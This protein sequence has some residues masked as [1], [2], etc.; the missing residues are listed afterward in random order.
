MQTSSFLRARRSLRLGGVSVL[1]LAAAAGLAGSSYGAGDPDKAVDHIRTASPIKHVI[2]IVGENRSFDHLFAT[3]VPKTPGERVLNLLSEHIINADGSPGPR[4]DRGHQFKIVAPPNGGKFFISADMV[5][6]QLYTT[7]PPPDIGGVPPV[8]IA[9]PIAEPPIFPPGDPGLPLEDQGL[10]ATGGTG[11]TG[12]PPPT[13]GPDTRITNVNNLQPGPF[14]MTGPTMPYDAYTGA[15]IHQYF[16]MYQQMDCAIDAEHVSPGNPTGCLHDLQSAVTT[17]FATLPTQTP[18]DTGQTMA[19]F[20]MQHGDVPFFKMLA[21]TYTMSDN[22][23]QPVMGGTGPDSQPLGFADQV[24]FSDGH[25]NAAAPPAANIYNPDPLTGTLNTY[26]HRAQW[27]DCSNPTGQ[28]GVKPILD[29]LAALP[30]TVQTGCDAGHFW[31]AVNVNP[32]FKPKGAPQPGLI[33]PPTMQRSIGDVL[34]AHSIPWKY[35]GGGFNV[36]DQ[37]TNPLTGLYCNICNP[38][39]YEVTYPSMVADHMRDVTDL[40]VDL[41]NGTLPAVAYVK[42]D[43]AMDGHPASSKFN[44]FEAFAENIVELAQTNKEQWAET[45]I[46]ITVDEGGGY[47]DSGFI[48]PVDFFGTGPRIPMIAVSPFSR[49]GHISHHYNEHSS[50]VKFVERNW[51]LSEKLS[52]RSRDNLPNPERDDDNPYVPANMPA[53]GDLFDLFDFDRDGDDRDHG[54]GDRDDHHHDDDR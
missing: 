44:L 36:S 45:A 12:S 37:P 18:H 39:E 24:F 54:H 38:F 6:K 13:L 1:A 27:F 4:F 32:A 42:P 31:Q 7:L 8:S 21:D 11:F 53:I 51:M 33:V 35:Y 48:E 52:D 41:Q 15:T 20:N 50:F 3:Y 5:D 23:H 10:F 17:T 2:I 9:A 30:F 43:G 22:Y 47:Y 46:F 19:F 26:T 40:F 49:G 28:P 25:G 29:Y 34:S 14:Q 16:Q